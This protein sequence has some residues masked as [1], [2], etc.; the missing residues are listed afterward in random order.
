MGNKWVTIGLKRGEALRSQKKV[1]IKDIARLSG[2][3]VATVSR[4]INRNGRFSE[5][6]RKRVEAVIQE[7]HYTTDMTG[8]SLRENRTHTI[9]VIVPDITNELF[10]TIV[11]ELE[12]NFF[13]QGYSVLICNTNEEDKKEA[14]YFKILESKS[15]DGIICIS[16]S[17]D[18]PEHIPLSRQ[19]EF[20]RIKNIVIQEAVRLGAQL[21]QDHAAPTPQAIAAGQ[22]NDEH[23][24]ALLAN[25]VTRLLHH[26]SRI[27]QEQ[28]PPAS[29]VY[30][31]DRKLLRKL[32]EKKIAHGHKPDD[33]APKLS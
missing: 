1:S 23:S 20:K 24:S 25:S 21:E 13:D 22:K 12:K 29:P 30:H 6:T 10:A 15:V 31:T 8:K 17:E 28:P 26:M 16:G 5:E 11:L 2:V 3:S 7:Y 9:G 27:F 18:L 32:R 33:H 19:K 14:A 4:V